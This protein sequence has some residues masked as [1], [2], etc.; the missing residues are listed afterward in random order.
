MS[1]L[2]IGIDLGTTNSVIAYYNTNTD[3]VEIIPNHLGERLTPSVVCYT[4]NETLV[5]KPALENTDYPIISHVKR[6]IGLKQ[7]QCENITDYLEY[8]VEFDNEGNPMIPISISN[9][10]NK[11]EELE[12]TDKMEET[13]K[14]EETEATDKIEST[15]ETQKNKKLL[16]PEEISAEVLYYLKRC[17]EE[18]LNERITDVVIT[19][20]A[21]FNDAQRR[22]TKD[23][24]TIA[25]LNCIRLIAEPT[26]ACLCYGLNKKNDEKLLVYDSGGGTLD[27]S[28]MN[29]CD[30]IFEVVATSGDTQ[31]GGADI[32]NII[33]DY[34]EKLYLVQT[35]KKVNIPQATAENIKK[36]LSSAT[37]TT[38]RLPDFKYVFTRTQLELLLNDF[39]EK[40]LEPV[41]KALTDANLKTSDISQI[42]LVGGTT[43]IP[44]L[45]QKLR[46]MFGSGTN[47]NKTVNPDEAVAYGAA[48]QSSILKNQGSRCKDLLLLDVCPLSL[49]IETAGGTMTTIIK[50]NSGLPTETS[51]MF[52][53][54]EDNQETV[55][56]KIFQGE[57]QF[58]KDCI[59]LGIFTLTGL[60]KKQPRGVPK[61]KVTFRL[62]CD[63]LLEVEATDKNTGLTSQISIKPETNLTETQLQKLLQDAEK[64][65]HKDLTRKQ[66]LDEL[67]SFQ[68]YIHEIQTIVNEPE[69]RELLTNKSHTQHHPTQ[70]SHTQQHPTLQHPTLSKT[71]QYLLSVLEWIENNREDT[72]NLTLETVQQYRNT[73]ELKIKPTLDYIYSYKTQLKGMKQLTGIEE[74]NDNNDNNNNI[75]ITKNNCEN[76]EQLNDLMEQMC[77]GLK[78]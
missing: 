44:Y 20:P 45:Q 56:I 51:K 48:I 54:A 53:T 35:G 46:E 47:L 36:T 63:G 37:Q 62:N 15:E 76:E 69:N 30:G 14:I 4:E 73:T 11:T 75:K 22:A 26:A 65:R 18:Y 21:Y 58:T 42:V 70:Q 1:N 74:G 71:N 50:R 24:A 2:S 34:L 32:D 78:L 60:P 67:T 55:D 28:V 41:D 57:R 5:G 29:V 17:G 77:S 43:R 10:K 39:M 19:V 8:E 25:G 33:T 72:K 64:H 12:E 66:L 9:E 38:V 68:K 6:L 40:S 49:G 27:V 52:S 31:L 13:D 61:I 3:A 16:K 23:A 7:K 59:P